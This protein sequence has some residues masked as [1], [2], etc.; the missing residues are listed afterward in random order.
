MIVSTCWAALG[1]IGRRQVP[2]AGLLLHIV[3]AV[4]NPV[5]GA[6]WVVVAAV[7]RTVLGVNGNLGSSSPPVGR[8]TVIP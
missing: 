5:L 7:N 4:Q 6:I 3:T 2:D 8:G 1:V